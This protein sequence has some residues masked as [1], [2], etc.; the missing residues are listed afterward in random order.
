MVEN[1]AHVRSDQVVD[2]HLEEVLDDIA[3]LL[4]WLELDLHVVHADVRCQGFL[5]RHLLCGSDLVHPS[6]GFGYVGAGR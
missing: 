3:R 5:N 4:C 1:R 2:V 6:V